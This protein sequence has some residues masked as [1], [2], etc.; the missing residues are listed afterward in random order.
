MMYR[1]LI[2]SW[3]TSKP[4]T[5]W[6]RT[7]GRAERGHTLP[8]TITTGTSLPGSPCWSPGCEGLMAEMGGVFV[9]AVVVTGRCGDGSCEVHCT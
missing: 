1:C 2:S 5:T 9:G 3:L 4:S 7:A 6:R 8:G